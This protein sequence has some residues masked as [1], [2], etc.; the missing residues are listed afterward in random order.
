M[1]KKEKAARPA[2]AFSCLKDHISIELRAQALIEAGEVVDAPYVEETLE[3]SDHVKS[4]LNSLFKN[5]NFCVFVDS[6]R[7]KALD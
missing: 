7:M 2:S 6:F 5:E 3:M 4:H 1:A